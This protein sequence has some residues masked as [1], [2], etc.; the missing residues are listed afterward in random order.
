M[1][2]EQGFELVNDEKVHR[3]IYGT[4]GQGGSA[5]GGVGEEATEAEILAEYDR[6]GGLITKNGDKVKMGCFY[7]FK[8]RK[9]H[10]DP[11]VIL[12]FQVN[13]KVVE[14]PANEPLPVLV[15]AAKIADEQNAEERT[16]KRKKGNASG[17]IKDVEDEA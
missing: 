10:K 9:P 14:V 13:N 8:G 6:L 16:T 1:T 5:V 7:D 11:K 15:Q 4:V 12:V 17:K 2:T 3:A